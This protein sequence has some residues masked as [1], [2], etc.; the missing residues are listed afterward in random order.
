MSFVRLK[1][2]AGHQYAYLVDNYW[3]PKGSRQRTKAY[4]GRA[5]IVTNTVE[6]SYDTPPTDYKTLITWL[7]TKELQKKGFAGKKILKYEDIRADLNKGKITRKKKNIVIPN[8]EGFI[9]EHTYNTL[10]KY[11]PKKEHYEKELA[12]HILEAGI[13]MPK[14]LFIRIIE[15]LK[16][17]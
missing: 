17:N 9:S 14:D 10:K 5:I 12:Q 16:K 2:I 11:T 6:V 13:N 8:H 15:A 3:T 4:L 7:I 1:T